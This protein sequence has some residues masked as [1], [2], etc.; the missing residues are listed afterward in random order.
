MMG[1]YHPITNKL[2][3]HNCWMAD[4]VKDYIAWASQHNFAIIDVNIPK[5]VT[6]ENSS[7]GKFEEDDVD[8]PNQTEELAG[9]LWDN[10]IEPNEATQVFFMGI[11]DA[12]YGVA[13]L[14]IN[15]DSIYQRV[16][17]VIS[18][19]AE[20]PVRA[21]ASPTQTW[22]SRWYK[23]N[24]LVFVSHAHGVWHTTE[25]RRKPSKRYG[26]LLRSPKAGLNEML[27][28]HKTEVYTWIEQRVNIRTGDETE[29]EEGVEDQQ[30]QQQQNLRKAVGMNNG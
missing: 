3:A 25:N 24:S 12:F 9:Y 27:L 20:N 5:H 17:S 16:N 11:G 7:V 14:L 10:Y 15:R 28:H 8:R 18:F 23:D 29:D 13:N 1:I 2:E 21:V 4:V 26:R 6:A 22:L 30:E 19:V